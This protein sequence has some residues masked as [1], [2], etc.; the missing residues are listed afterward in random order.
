MSFKP[1]SYLQ[2]DA[3]WKN[4][5]Y[6]TPQENTTIGGSGCGPTAA[7]MVASE[8]ADAGETP[9]SACSWSMANGYKATGQGT[10]YSFFEPYFKRFGLKCERPNTVNLYH[11]PGASVHT[12]VYNAVKNGDY[13]IA[14]MGVGRWTSSGHFVLWYGIDGDNVLLNDPNS[15]AANRTNAAWSFFRNEVKYYFII[16]KPTNLKS[17]AATAYT[18]TDPDG[19]L[20]VRYGAGTGYNIMGK[21]LAGTVLNIEKVAGS[22]ARF[23]QGGVR[24]Y[25]NTA[26]LTNGIA[27]ASVEKAIDTLSKKG[28]ID[29]PDYWKGHAGDVPYLDT[30]LIRIANM[31]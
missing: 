4:V 3:K 15:T 27:P 18:V 31:L 19:Y 28:V 17:G 20:N 2:T 30:L 8:W 22:W 11:N 21:S 14:C 29:S 9:L 10:Y 5:K 26:G 24:Y 16:H 13:V 23:V 1:V 25:V 12:T 6:A 7:A